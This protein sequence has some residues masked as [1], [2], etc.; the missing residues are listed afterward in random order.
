MTSYQVSS[1]GKLYIAGEYA[2]LEPNQLAIIKN[3]PIKMTA[4]IYFSDEYVISSDLFDYQVSLDSPDK[5]YA[6]LRTAILAM[7]AFLETR[8]ITAKPFTIEIKSQMGEKGKKFGIGSSGSI[9]VLVIRAYSALYQLDLSQELIFKLAS[10]I[11]L[12][13]GDNGSMGDIACIV[14]DTCVLYQSF[15]RQKI[16]QMMDMSSMTEVL[17]AEWGFKISPVNSKLVAT[18][19]VGWTQKPAISSQFIEKVKTSINDD[20][21]RKSQKNVL[22]LMKAMEN[23][24]QDKFITVL[25]QLTQLIEDLHPD[26]YNK[27]LRQLREDCNGLNAIAKS[28]GAGGG[29]CGIAFSFDK[30]SETDLMK[31]WQDHDITLIYKENLYDKS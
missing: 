23:G 16:R 30:V 13:Q 18:F 24:N 20:F 7:N 27:E 21:L 17:S 2:I 25:S 9:L 22:L 10:Y 31:R 29:D 1:C 5:N 6:F 12:S 3:I 15:E 14:Y 4:D 11:L 19:L 8:Q 28:S 26:I